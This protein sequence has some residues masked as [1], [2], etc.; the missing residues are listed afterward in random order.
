MSLCPSVTETLI[1]FGAAD[2]I[3]GITRFCIHPK[4]VVQTLD[5]VGGTKDPDLEAIRAKNPDLILLNE[6]EN[7]RED[8][9]AL[10]SDF[11]VQTSLPKRV[12]EVPE[13]LRR[14]GS[15]VGCEDIAERRAAE[16]EAAL[17][18]LGATE[19]SFSYAYLIWR[20]PWMTVNDDTYVADLIGR[21]GGMNVFGAAPDRYPTITLDTL[22]ERAPDVVFLPDEPF[23]FQAKHAAEI[24]TGQVELV[25]GDDCCWHG[26]RSIRG[27]ELM[28]DLRAKLARP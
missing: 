27:V 28:R 21:A 3:V 5:R 22:A 4:E 12:T 26:V 25:S 10:A 23:P 9:D 8:H 6:E 7:R 11:D 14:L 24:P 1:D 17:E 20:S 19:G 13:E 16:L 15:L 18:T 2:R